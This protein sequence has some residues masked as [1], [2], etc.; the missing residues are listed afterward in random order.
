MHIIEKARLE[1]QTIYHLICIM[2]IVFK[3]SHGQN[4][5]VFC[6]FIDFL[7]REKNWKECAH[8]VR[9]EH[10]VW[11]RCGVWIVLWLHLASRQTDL[12]SLFLYCMVGDRKCERQR[13]HTRTQLIWIIVNVYGECLIIVLYSSRPTVAQI[14]SASPLWLGRISK[15][16]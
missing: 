7:K 3:C 15:T 6:Y 5:I 10:W 1:N 9:T 8:C 16:E 11:A 2:S 13:T 14:P 4:P 12:V